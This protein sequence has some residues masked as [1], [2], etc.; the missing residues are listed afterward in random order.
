MLLPHIG[1]GTQETRQ[2]MEKLVLEN[3]RTFFSE[4]PFIDPGDANAP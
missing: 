4:W 3:L 2:V 1:S